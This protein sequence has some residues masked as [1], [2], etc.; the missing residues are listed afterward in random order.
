MAN[1]VAQDKMRYGISALDTK[2][3]GVAERDELLVQSRDGRM[4]YRRLDGQFV[5]ASNDYDKKSLQSD[6]IASKIEYT[7]TNNTHVAYHTIDITEKTDLSKAT[8]INLDISDYVF[9]IPN[10]R[11][12][13]CIRVRGN[14]ITNGAVSLIKALYRAQSPYDSNEEVILTLHAKMPM[15]E[16]DLNVGCTFNELS[17]INLGTDE[18]CDFFI[19]S[20]TFP[21]LASAFAALDESQKLQFAEYNMNNNLFEASTLDIVTLVTD[22]STLPIYHNNGQMC[23]KMVY[24][25]Q[26]LILQ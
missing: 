4:F 2:Y 18:E 21:K 12:S 11:T 19:K 1:I 15:M 9:K 8:T 25:I 5:T 24:P 26:K 10:G 13:L 20:I 3:R 6:L 22:V 23:L 17:Y 14:D 7:L 16:K